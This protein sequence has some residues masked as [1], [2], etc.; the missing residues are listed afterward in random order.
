MS[1]LIF[2]QTVCESGCAKEIKKKKVILEK[3]QQT[4][5][6]KSEKTS[7]QIIVFCAVFGICVVTTYQ[8]IIIFLFLSAVKMQKEILNLEKNTHF[9]CSHHVELDIK[10]WMKS[11]SL[12]SCILIH[13]KFIH[14]QDPFILNLF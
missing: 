13:C 12:F 8:N 10:P 2:V 6:K 14:I 9:D 5:K 11:I 1:G 4:T 7:M 3:S